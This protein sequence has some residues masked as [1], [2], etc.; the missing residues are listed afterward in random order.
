MAPLVPSGEVSRS[1]YA[2]LYDRVMLK[3]AGRQRYAT[4]LM[5]LD[6]KRV[7]QPL[8]NEHSV[9]RLRAEMGLD[10]FASYLKSADAIFAQCPSSGVSG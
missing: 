5:C 9:D 3:V 2:Y 8:E 7:A 6:G 4:Q 10:P 1:D